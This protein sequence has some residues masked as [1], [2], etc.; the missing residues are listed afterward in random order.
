MTTA[1]TVV[2]AARVHTMHE[3][4]EHVDAIAIAGGRIIGTGRFAELAHV[5]G[6]HTEVFEFAAATIVPGLNDSHMHPIY[7]LSVARGTSLVGVTTY[8]GLREAL[9]RGR[10]EQ[11]ENEWS[12]AWGLDPNAFEGRPLNND[13]L[14]DVFGDERP[15]YVKMFDAHG[16]LAS[17]AALARA[18]ITEPSR[19]S[20]GA[21]VVDDGTGRPSGLLLEFPAMDRVEAVIPTPTFE[22][23]TRQLRALLG[24]IAALGITSAHVM[25]LKD[26]DALDL[27]RAIEADGELSVRLRLSP[28]CEPSTTDDDIARLVALQGTGGRRFR[29]EGVKFFI[30]GTVEGGT[31]WLDTPDADGQCLTATWSDHDAYVSRI[32]LFHD[33]GIPTTTHAIGERGIRFAAETLAALPPGAPGAPQHR[34]EHLESADDDTIALLSAHG[35]A[36]S[37]QPTHC[38]HFVRADGSD[39]WSRRLGP[40][41]A[42]HAWRTGDIRRAGVTLALGSDWPVAGFDPWAI[43]AAAQ[44]RR[45]AERP[46]MPPVGF[47]QALAAHQALEGYTT[48]AHSSVGSAGGTLAVGAPADLVVIDVDPLSAA[49]EDM[50]RARP[51]LTLLEGIPTYAAPSHAPA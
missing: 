9:E 14:R 18:G 6:S 3:G 25:D 28:W 45:P 12:F 51:L 38:T 2:R 15:V 37:M 36:A 41:R 42:A 4:S 27:L 8:D 23:R 7:S 35:I 44:L 31:A 19:S 10:D 49:P 16:A 32:R 5:V 21:T 17:D 11:R 39:D 1:D 26:D 34:I 33:R 29:V 13:L 30:D 20:D 48:H 24:D 43:M 22:S 40:E 46:S 47:D 50:A